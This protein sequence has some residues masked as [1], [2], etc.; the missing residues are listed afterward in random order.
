MKAKLVVI[1]YVKILILISS[2]VSG[3][4]PT[5]EGYRVT[6]NPKDHLLTKES[7]KI[8]IDQPFILTV[9][10]LSSKNINYVHAYK[11]DWIK[12]QRS[13]TTRRCA[14][15]KGKVAN[16]AFPDAEL[17]VVK[18]SNPLQI[19]VDPLRPNTYFDIHVVYDLPDSL[20]IILDKV[21]MVLANSVRPD[22]SVAI[23]KYKELTDALEDPYSEISY[24]GL[25]YSDY[26]K[27]F[28]L[29]LLPI[30]ES[31]KDLKKYSYVDSITVLE[32]KGVAALSIKQATVPIELSY[33]L[34]IAKGLQFSAFMD[35]RLDV[36]KLKASDRLVPV[37]DYASRLAN[38]QS[39]IKY[40]DDLARRLDN[41]LTNSRTTPGSRES[42]TLVES[43]RFKLRNII[44]E[45]LI[46]NLEKVQVP[47]KLIALEV[48][49]IEDLKANV[50]LA[51]DNYSP[52]LKTKGGTYLFIDAGLTNIVARGLDKKPTY[53]PR[54]YLG[55]S[56]YFRPID[57]NTRQNQLRRRQDLEDYNQ[58]F[59][60]IEGKQKGGFDYEMFSTKNIW[61]HLSLNLGF[62]LGKLP[63]VEFDN[64]YNDMSLLIGPAYRFKGAFKV[65]VG[66][67][68]LRRSSFNPLVEEKKVVAGIYGSLSVDIDLLDS[69]K[70][71]TSKLF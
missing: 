31:N 35:G 18:N 67:A 15:C 68:L 7:L 45:S 63:N 44:S 12:G 33:M 64:F 5:Y 6:Y 16:Y 22:D 28:D 21:N 62:T 34:T 19:E 49:K 59:T 56:I 10:G 37:Q 39:N 32:I 43:A 48:D 57:R 55:L 17:K 53:I 9:L 60:C 70:S 65:S 24:A 30:Y 61:Q 20:R 25:D 51:G 50:F 54:L 69:I 14:D 1:L 38:I 40:I 52:D 3:Q 26:K 4:G 58:G 46:K 66:S 41:L 42:N 71:L 11:V 36:Y 27:I 8:P 13:K 2:K 23:K 29:R 47:A